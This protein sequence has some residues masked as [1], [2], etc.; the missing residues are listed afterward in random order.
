[1][2]R[3]IARWLQGRGL[4]AELAGIDLNP[5]SGPVA[6]AATD[7]SLGITYHS[8]RAEALG[9]Q[10]DF[11]ISSLVAHHM[12]DDELVAFIQWMERT[13]RVGWL[14]NDLHR[15]WLAWAGFR[16]LAFVFRWHPIVAHDGALSVRRAFTRAE[17][18]ALLAAAGVQA[19][20]RWHFPFR[21]TVESCPR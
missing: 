17:L 5:R 9:W 14:I 11:I 7:P 6:A 21:W 8:G 1:M 19:E 10:P 12:R 3:A 2:L 20:L 18:E 16:T 15:H 4:H 13:A